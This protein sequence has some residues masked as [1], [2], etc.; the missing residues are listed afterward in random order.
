MDVIAGICLAPV[1]A[2]HFSA[3]LRQTHV[4]IDSKSSLSP[5]SSISEHKAW[6]NL[7]KKVKK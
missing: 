6:M 1:S 7:N 5:D 2:S 3:T 4:K